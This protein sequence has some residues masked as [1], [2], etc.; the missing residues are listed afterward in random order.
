MASS[1]MLRVGLRPGGA[2]RPRMAGVSAGRLPRQLSEPTGN[3]RCHTVSL[4]S[5]VRTVMRAAPLT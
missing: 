5:F 3:S 2:V 4:V 1:P